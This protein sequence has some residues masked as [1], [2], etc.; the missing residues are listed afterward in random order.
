ME[1]IRSSQN[2]K[3]RI[4][5]LEIKQLTE[6]VDLKQQL[7]YTVENLKPL[8]LLK[9]SLKEAVTSPDL[10]QNIIGA[11]VGLASGYLSKAVI[12]G[13]SHNP[14]KKMAGSVVQ[15]M[16]SSSIARHPEMVNKLATGLLRVLGKKGEAK[17]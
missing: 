9:T 10:K 12:V 14:L 8:N 4:Q 17:E 3:D 7:S 15:L 16:I 11:A 1:I 13:D 5:A 6:L 2:L